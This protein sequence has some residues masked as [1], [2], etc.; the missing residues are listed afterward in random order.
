[1]NIVERAKQIKQAAEDLE[2]AKE[3][4][5]KRHREIDAERKRNLQAEVN[6]LL[7]SL[8][9][10]FSVKSNER[11]QSI[12]YGE[13]EIMQITMQ[14]LEYEDSWSANKDTVIDL[15]IV[16]RP[17]NGGNEISSKHIG[18]FSE[19]FAVFLSKYV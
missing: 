14:W 12:L 1:M 4:E 3:I 2:K 10:P 11:C 8:T 5:L 7:E 15:F 16:G 6:T 19:S 9:E 13:Q 18:R 17:T